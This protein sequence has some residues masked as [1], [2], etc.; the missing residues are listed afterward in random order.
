MV[1]ALTEPY[2]PVETKT[3]VFLFL[4]YQFQWESNMSIIFFTPG[5]IDFE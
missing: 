3:K 5:Q 2:A 1:A 4:R